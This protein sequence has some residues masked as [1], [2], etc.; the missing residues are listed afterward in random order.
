M[1]FFRLLR[2]QRSRVRDDKIAAAAHANAMTCGPARLP[3]IKEGSGR[4]A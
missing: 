1:G 2:V 4:R 3:V